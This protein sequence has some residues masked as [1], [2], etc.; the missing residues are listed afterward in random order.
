MNR[1]L[2]VFWLPL[3]FLTVALVGGTLLF[4]IATW[5]HPVPAGIWR[6]IA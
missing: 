1:A 4:L 5:V 2:E 3:L 6:W